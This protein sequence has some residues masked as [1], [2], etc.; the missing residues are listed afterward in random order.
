MAH[1]I[2]MKF[3][4]TGLLGRQQT[5][6]LLDDRALRI[7]EKRNKR[8]REYS[9]DLLALDPNSQRRF[10]WCWSWLT[11]SGLTLS[12]VL[13]LFWLL[14]YYLP[15]AADG[16][17]LLTLVLGSLLTI[18]QLYL[19]WKYSS[20]QQVFLSR[21]ANIPLLKLQINQPSRNEFE[22]FVQRL[23]QRITE[24]DENFELSTQQ[25]LSGELRMLRR[26]SK[27]Q[28]ITHAQYAQAKEELFGRFEESPAP[29][30]PLPDMADA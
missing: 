19:F 22:Q 3:A 23:V 29:D 12:G 30:V 14:Q 16:Y 1:Q 6:Q 24:L 20:R 21:H 4:Q 11:G 5:I 15:G 17:L 26:L 27:N 8:Q 28:V 18:G 13:V 10:A 2:T 25:Q 7:R 9:I